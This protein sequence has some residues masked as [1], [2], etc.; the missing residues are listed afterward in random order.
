MNKKE[1]TTILQTALF[2]FDGA[3]EQEIMNLNPDYN[4]KLVRAG[5]SLC[6]YLQEQR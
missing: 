3:T 5:C 4:L 6:K 1:F 2:S